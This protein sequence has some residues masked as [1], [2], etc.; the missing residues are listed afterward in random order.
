MEGGS[1]DQKAMDG[2]VDDRPRELGYLAEGD[3]TGVI[4]RGDCRGVVVVI[5]FPRLS[6]SCS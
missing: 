1:E 4:E 3:V 5:K 6:S 2:Y